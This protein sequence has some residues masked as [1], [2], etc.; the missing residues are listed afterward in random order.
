MLVVGHNCPGCGLDTPSL[1]CAACGAQVVWDR[2][3]GSHCSACGLSAQIFTCVEC[4]L[5]TE[6]DKRQAPPAARAMTPSPPHDRDAAREQAPR[7]PAMLARVGTALRARVPIRTA[8][9]ATA[10]GL[11]GLLI[12][13]LVGGHDGGRAL[14]GDAAVADAATAQAPHRL[15]RGAFQLPL[16]ARPVPLLPPPPGSEPPPPPDAG[17]DAPVIVTRIDRGAQPAPRHEGWL[18]RIWRSRRAYSPAN[19]RFPADTAG[20]GG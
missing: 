1:A 13:L 10:A 11:H 14:V 6:L 19:D 4:G 18:Q 5:H 17:W 3:D 12:A 15:M 16:D 7:S 9:I 2:E 8:G 20:I